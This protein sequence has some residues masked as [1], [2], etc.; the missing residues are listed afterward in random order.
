MTSPH[1]AAGD[2]AAL[3]LNPQLLAALAAK[4]HVVPTPIQAQAIPAMLSCQFCINL[5]PRNTSRSAACHG[6]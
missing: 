2:F 3:H 5:P 4:D 1:Q 6:R